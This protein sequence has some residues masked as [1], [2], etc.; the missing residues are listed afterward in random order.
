VTRFGLGVSN[1]HSALDVV[2]RVRRAEKLGAEIAFIA[3]DVNCRDAFELCALSAMQT[4][5]IRLGTGVVNPFTRNPTALAMAIAT[6]DEISQG[7]AVLGLGT[8]SPSLI[9]DQMGIPT[10]KPVRAMRETTEIIRALL[11][12][13]SLTYPGERFVY[14]AARLQVHPVQARLPIYFGAM[15][16]QMLRLAGR[17]AD[18]VLLNVGASTDY[19]LWSVGEVHAGAVAAGRTPNEVTIA[20]WLSVYLTKDYEAGVQRAKEWL[21][22][23]LSVPRQGE[24]LLEHSNLDTSILGNIRSL[25]GG[26]PHTGDRLA[27]AAVVP[28][29]VA[30]RL[31]LIGTLEQVRERIEEYRAAGVDVPVLGPSALRALM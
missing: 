26:Y 19:I 5:R 17:I 8:S 16:P 3:E 13:E 23:M 12:G 14:A 10:H 6:L 4:T 29:Q 31:T 24:L 1:C 30:E 7:R 27:A 20:A 9:E 2:A 28:R 15:G 25:V 21:A 11:R 18:G 22:T